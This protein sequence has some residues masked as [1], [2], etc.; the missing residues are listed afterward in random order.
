MS[1]ILGRLKQMFRSV[2]KSASIVLRNGE[3]IEWYGESTDALAIATFFR[4]C[5]VLADSVATLPMQYLTRRNG[6]YYEDTS[7]PMY[8]LLAVEPQ[9]ER[10]I[11]D[12]WSYALKQICIKG[13]AY[14]YPRKV[15]GVV[16]DLVLCSS[17]TVSYYDSTGTYTICDPYNGVYATC[18]EEDIIHLFFNTCDGRRGE[19]ILTHA[20]RT[21]G[22]AAA[23]DEETRNRF[24]NGGTVRGIVSNDK[25]TTGYGEYQD[26]ELQKT[27]TDIEGYL[28]E[29]HR[30][31]SLPGQVGF[32]QLSLSSTDMQFLESRKFTVREICRF[33]GVNPSYVFD[34]SASNYKSA[35][36]ARL[37]F[38]QTTL[39]PILRRIEAE[40][41]RKLIPADRCCENIFRF[42][43]LQSLSLDHTTRAAYQKATIEN[44]LYTVNEWR[45]TEGRPTIEGGDTPLISANLVPLATIQ[46]KKN[47]KKRN[48][49][50]N[51]NY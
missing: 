23:G 35:E 29:G 33:F 6:V 34:D 38:L 3:Y 25:S 46:N 37:D 15:N 39:N 41:N 42:D 30:I 1:K 21:V 28:G 10:S 9:P 19:S 11:Y 7:S 43:R 26:D 18:R 27:A 32:Q 4:C 13:N 24:K 51:L 48:Q 44:G 36:M 8:R 17:D 14:I 12:F 45:R 16:T 49:E 31:V 50:R 47:E 2:S 5:N 20:R 22:I 40:F